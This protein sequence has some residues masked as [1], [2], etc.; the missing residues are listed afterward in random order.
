M[1]CLQNTE[2]CGISTTSLGSLLKIPNV[3]L[4]HS[5][6]LLCAIPLRC[7]KFPGGILIVVI[8]KRNTGKKTLHVDLDTRF[9]T[10]FYCCKCWHWSEVHKETHKFHRYIFWNG[11]S[12]DT[13]F[14]LLISYTYI[15]TFV[16]MDV[17]CLKTS[18]S[19]F[20][21]GRMFCVFSSCWAKGL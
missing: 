19:L 13:I 20:S 7:L 2:R 16:S 10:C 21:W 4:E 11:S 14:C 17:L 15:F 8:I 18:W 6:V 9:H 5:L 12:R 1:L 3:Q